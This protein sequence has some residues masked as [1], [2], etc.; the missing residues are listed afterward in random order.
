M[1]SQEMLKSFRRYEKIIN[2]IEERIDE[3]KEEILREIY[4]QL[5]CDHENIKKI[6]SNYTWE[7]S[8]AIDGY[9]TKRKIQK[10]IMDIY[11]ITDKSIQNNKIMKNMGQSREEF[12]RSIKQR[13]NF[14][15]REILNDK[16][17][18][19]NL[20]EP[21]NIK[22]IETML[23][24]LEDSIIKLDN[25][26]FWNYRINRTKIQLFNIN[27]NQMIYAL[28]MQEGYVYYSNVSTEEGENINHIVSLV[29]NNMLL[30]N[31]EEIKDRMKKGEFAKNV[32]VGE[33]IGINK[34][35]ES[36]I[37][38]LAFSLYNKEIFN[39][40]IVCNGIAYYLMQKEDLRVFIEQFSLPLQIANYVSIL[41]KSKPFIEE[42]CVYNIGINICKNAEKVFYETQQQLLVKSQ[43][44]IDYNYMLAIQEVSKDLSSIEKVVF[45]FF[46]HMEK[47][48]ENKVTLDEA[49]EMIKKN[50]KNLTKEEFEKAIKELLLKG[51]IWLR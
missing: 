32:T 27:L 21:I 33:V 3:S 1:L 30:N 48:Y 14:T 50:Y 34:N 46:I 26:D 44:D 8:L 12:S 28:L 22:D 7:A 5:N 13:Y 51:Y 24:E 41:S 38:D 15:L 18:L 9:I 19:P 49:Y 6:F 20:Q 35:N 31:W 23:N 17:L 11:D 37:A 40:G 47:S 39:G 36:E 2:I 45:Y 25:L 16:A 42:I 10:T 29:A 43:Y 4:I